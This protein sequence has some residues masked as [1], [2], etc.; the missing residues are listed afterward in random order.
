[1]HIKQNWIPVQHALNR[2]YYKGILPLTDEA[3]ILLYGNRFGRTFQAQ[4]ID[5]GGVNKGDTRNVI[6]RSEISIHNG[7]TG[8]GCIDTAKRS[9]IGFVYDHAKG[10]QLSTRKHNDSFWDKI[11][12]AMN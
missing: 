6:I 10:Y 11:Y 4:L 7:K 5:T 8:E 2:F 3:Y 1:M 9:A 12:K